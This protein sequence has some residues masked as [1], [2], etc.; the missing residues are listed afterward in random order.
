MKDLCN[1]FKLSL[2]KIRILVIGII[3]AFF[4]K[5]IKKILV[6]RMRLIFKAIILEKLIL[7]IIFN[8]M[9][10]IKMLF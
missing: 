10:L 3:E 1:N 7:V 2:L 4:C 5:K 6:L 8:R 9:D